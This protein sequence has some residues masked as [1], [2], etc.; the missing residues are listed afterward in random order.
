MR[1]AAYKERHVSTTSNSY[2]EGQPPASQAEVTVLH[3]EHLEVVC[4]SG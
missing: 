2:P 1:K 4:Q 3:A